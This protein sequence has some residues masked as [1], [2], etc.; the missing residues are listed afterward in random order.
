MIIVFNLQEQLLNVSI[1]AQI[2]DPL[3]PLGFSFN[4]LYWLLR[5]STND[6]YT[7]FVMCTFFTANTLMFLTFF[8]KIQS[9]DFLWFRGEG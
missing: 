6:L 4:A 9:E 2:A 8:E 1:R 7:G 5:T 3:L